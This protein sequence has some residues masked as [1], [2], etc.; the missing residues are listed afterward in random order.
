MLH[1]MKSIV[2]ILF[3][4]PSI[5]LQAQNWEERMSFSATLIYFQPITDLNGTPPVNN[6]LNL[7]LDAGISYD[8]EPRLHLRGNWIFGMLDG[9]E[10]QH[11]YFKTVFNEAAIFLDYDIMPWVKS[12]STY[13][14]HISG[15]IGMMFFT[16]NLFDSAGK[17]KELIARHPSN[18]V[19]WTYA[20]T[21]NLGTS[22]H[23][24]LSSRFGLTLGADLKYLLNTDL[25]D[26]YG[27]VE[28]GSDMLGTL[29][30]GMSFELGRSLKEGEVVTKKSVYDEFINQEARAQAELTKAKE[31]LEEARKASER[32]EKEREE[33]AQVLA[34]KDQQISALNNALAQKQPSTYVPFSDKD[35]PSSKSVQEWEQTIGL[36]TSNKA[37]STASTSGMWHVVIGS[38]P[39][40]EAAFNYIQTMGLNAQQLQ[41]RFV[42]ELQTYRVLH[43][44]FSNQENA[45]AARDAIKDEFPKAWIIQF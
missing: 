31:I 6:R 38:F 20:G 39:A 7:G 9:G 33:T 19:P 28:G 18:D 15:G 1:R 29:E 40:E 16:S 43:S 45:A 23:I 4:L 17:G 12:Q 22:L 5:C 30:V 2:L 8:L 25:L 26:A 3:L 35:V 34:E 44:S 24:P 27:G 11:G 32:I 37:A 13:E 42:D 21:W 10:P 41:V 36:G 14:W